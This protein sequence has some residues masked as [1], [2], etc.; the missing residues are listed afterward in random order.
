MLVRRLSCRTLAFLATG[1]A[2]TVSPSH[3]ET[4]AVGGSLGASQEG[5]SGT[6]DAEVDQGL[7]EDDSDPALLPD[8]GFEHGL[9]LGVSLP[10]GRSDEGN[11]LRSGDLNG[12]V[13]V[14]I[15][16]WLDIGYRL[17]SNWWLGTAAQLGLG[18]AGSDCDDNQEC[19][20]SDLRLAAQAIY[21]LAPDASVDP[22]IG[23][24]LGWEWLRGSVT[25]TVP[26]SVVGQDQD[27]AVRLQ[28]VLSGPQLFL[29][30]G[31][32]FKLGEALTVGPFATAAAGVYLTDSVSCPDGVPACE[33]ANGIDDNQLH[34]WLGLGVR[35]THGP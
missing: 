6:A 26:G 2:L 4:A 23:L 3:A 5:V 11:E 19:E 17:N 18:T 9:R 35:G 15:P 14:R 12:V 21:S 30:G 27:I 20:W 25:L 13:G 24:G 1:F 22:W 28:E 33:S 7:T 29:Q 8:H 31:L 16:L 34:A 10:L 32:R